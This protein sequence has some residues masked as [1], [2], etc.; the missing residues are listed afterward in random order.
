MTGAES[1]RRLAE[2]HGVSEE[3]LQAAVNEEFARRGEERKRRREERL[4]IQTPNGRRHAAATDGIYRPHR[5]PVSVPDDRL[6]VAGAV[7]HWRTVHGLSARQA[8]ARIGLAMASGTWRT[9][10][11]SFAAPP[12]RTLLK[13]LAATGLGYWVDQEQR[14]NGDP[15]LE[16]EAL[17]ARERQ[18][19]Q[20][21]RERA[22]QR[23]VLLG[24]G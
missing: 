7:R 24:P 11:T 1:V 19:R 13:I 5:S 16:F 22:A 21:R 12:Y 2:K 20:A 3:A 15:T 6:Y 4:A 14:A 10:E 8:Q 9:W 18:D 17:R 23:A